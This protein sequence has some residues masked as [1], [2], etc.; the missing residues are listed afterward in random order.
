[1]LKSLTQMTSE[2]KEEDKQKA[3]TLIFLLGYLLQ[4]F[5]RLVTNSLATIDDMKLYADTLE[6]YSVELDNTLTAIF[7]Q[8]KKYAEEKSREQQELMK[9]DDAVSYVK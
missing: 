6:N 8:A 1:M 7:E 5:E 4:D 2:L 3:S 9:K